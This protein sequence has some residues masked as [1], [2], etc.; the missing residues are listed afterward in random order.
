MSDK[1]KWDPQTVQSIIA[2]LQHKPG[3]LLPILH[4]IQDALG[5]IPPDSVPM[6]ADALQQTRAEIH[7]VITFY[8]HFRLTPP[9]RI[10]LEVCRAEACQARGS[11]HLESHVK[12]RLGIDYHHTTLDREFSLEPV[13]CLGNCACG[14]T[15][16]VDDDIIGRITPEKF[17]LLVDELTT[18]ALEIR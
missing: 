13:Y 7:G 11:R 1:A 10:K 2:S 6:I 12:E 8:H 14:P 18:T 17:D 9:G 16:R 4:G 15:I 3:A 5:Y